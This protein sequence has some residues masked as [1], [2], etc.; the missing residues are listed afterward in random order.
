MVVG[1]R[2][3][4]S[5]ASL[6]PCS[7]HLSCCVLGRDTSPAMPADGGQRA[8]WRR[9]C[10]ILTSVSLPRAA[11]ATILAYCQCVNVCRNKWITD[12]SVKH[13]TSAGHLPFAITKPC[14]KSF[15]LNWDWNLWVKIVSFS[16]CFSGINKEEGWPTFNTNKK[17][18]HGIWGVDLC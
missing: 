7:L 8:Q 3:V 17:D 11:M 15:R 14:S 5:I 13:Y 1:V 9:L 4:T 12:C 2:P 18:V 6:N 16:V 10:G